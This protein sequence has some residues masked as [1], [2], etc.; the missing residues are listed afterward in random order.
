VTFAG[1]FGIEKGIKFDAECLIKL[2][3]KKMGI[4]IAD[5]HH[6]GFVNADFLYCDIWRYFFTNIFM[7]FWLNSQCIPSISPHQ[8]NVFY[9]IFL[10]V[11]ISIALIQLFAF[12]TYTTLYG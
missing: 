1:Y 4:I 6:M 3:F 12:I 10:F 5:D 9:L 8:Q 7:V 2:N 11:F